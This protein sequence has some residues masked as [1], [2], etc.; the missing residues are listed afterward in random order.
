[1]PTENEKKFLLTLECEPKIKAHAELTGSM[2]W[3]ISQGYLST[4]ATTVRL[5]HVINKPLGELY[6]KKFRHP[7]YQ[8]N[9]RWWLTIKRFVNDRCV[10]IENP[11]EQRDFSDLWTVAT[12]KL[13]KTRYKIYDETVSD[14]QNCWEIDFFRDQENSLYFVM[15]EIEL[16]EGMAMPDKIPDFIWENLIY[17]VP[18]NDHRFMNTHLG[19][20]EYAVNLYNECLKNPGKI[21]N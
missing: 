2:S 15:A 4:E 16:P 6:Y 13:I 21:P 5:R 18:L 1:M 14:G 8:N 20:R 17:T 7:S 12:D 3:E 11:I 19:D 9:E 10:E